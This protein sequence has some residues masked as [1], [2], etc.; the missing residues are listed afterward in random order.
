MV[1]PAYRHVSFTASWM[2]QTLHSA[3]EVFVSAQVVSV[4]LSGPGGNPVK[5]MKHWTHVP[6][7]AVPPAAGPEDAGTAGEAEGGA[8]AGRHLQR[9][10]SRPQKPVSSG[11]IAPGE[12]AHQSWWI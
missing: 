5:G 12:G 2:V 7:P 8:R 3:L 6:T 9:W 11:S 10:C 4:T 1:R